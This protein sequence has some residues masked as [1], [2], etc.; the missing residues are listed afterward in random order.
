MKKKKKPMPQP[1]RLGKGKMTNRP[2]HTRAYGFC[3]GYQPMAD[4][5][6]FIKDAAVY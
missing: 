2:L 5:D 6:I 3:K 1:N 4:M